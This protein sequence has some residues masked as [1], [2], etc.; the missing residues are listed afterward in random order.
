MSG[1]SPHTHTGSLTHTGLQPASALETQLGAPQT[2]DY[3]L[4]GDLVSFSFRDGDEEFTLASFHTASD[5]GEKQTL[6]RALPMR[7][8]KAVHGRSFA[9]AC[10]FRIIGEAPE[11]NPGDL[12]RY[13]TDIMLQH[14]TTGKYVSWRKQTAM[15][16]N[17]AF[18][19]HLSS[20]PSAQSKLTISPRYAFRAE[21]DRVGS[22]DPVLF[23]ASLSGHRDQF[24]EAYPISHVHS[25][26]GVDEK[27]LGDATDIFE[28]NMCKPRV[29]WHPKMFRRYIANEE[30]VLK[31]GDVIRLV[32]VDTGGALLVNNIAGQ[33]FELHVQPR[34]DPNTHSE[35]TGHDTHISIDYRSWSMWQVELVRS[36]DSVAD[37][38]DPSGKVVRREQRIRLR[39]LSTSRYLTAES[40]VEGGSGVCWRV[41]KHVSKQTV[42]V[43]RSTQS[44]EMD[45]GTGTGTDNIAYSASWCRIQHILTG[46]CIS[47]GSSGSGPGRVQGAAASEKDEKK[48]GLLQLKRAQSKW[49]VHSTSGVSASAFFDDSVGRNIN[50]FG[51]GASNLHD[52]E[53]ASVFEIHAVPREDVESFFLV[54]SRVPAMSDFVHRLF[55][56][57]AYLPQEHTSRMP[58][59][60]EEG[61][62]VAK[63]N[64]H[65][66]GNHSENR[67]DKDYLTDCASPS[68]PH[69]QQARAMGDDSPS[70]MLYFLKPYLFTRK[71]YD[72]PETQ[73]LTDKA[74]DDICEV[75]DYL[76]SHCTV[77]AE[78]QKLSMRRGGPILLHQNLI[79][80][81]RLI[82]YV[83]D[84][85]DLFFYLYVALCEEESA[86][87]ME[88]VRAA[89]GEAVEHKLT[90]SSSGPQSPSYYTAGKF[91]F[92]SNDADDDTLYA[93][94]TRILRYMQKIL[95]KAYTFIRLS[96]WRNPPMQLY[97]A[98]IKTASGDLFYRSLKKHL[99]VPDGIGDL[100]IKALRAI[101]RNNSVLLSEITASE[102][103]SFF[104]VPLS[105]QAG[106]A[107]FLAVFCIARDDFGLL[108]D[109]GINVH[110]DTCQKLI[111]NE[112][113]LQKAMIHSFAI[114]L[115]YPAYYN[116][117]VSGALTSDIPSLT[118]WNVILRRFSHE[119]KSAMLKR[120]DA[121][122]AEKKDRRRTSVIGLTD[123]GHFCCEL[124]SC[125]TDED[126]GLSAHALSMVHN[127]LFNY[128]H[129][130]DTLQ[131]M[132]QHH[133][134]DGK[135]R[136]EEFGEQD[137]DNSANASGLFSRAR[138]SFSN[139]SAH[140]NPRRA[141]NRSVSGPQ[142]VGLGRLTRSRGISM[143]SHERPSYIERSSALGGATESVDVAEVKS[144][145]VPR[146][147]L[148]EHTGHRV[149]IDAKL[150]GMLRDL[151]SF[152]NAKGAWHEKRVRSCL[153]LIRCLCFKN[154][155][156]S[157][158]FR[159]YFSMPIL[160]ALLKEKKEANE[161]KHA[162]S[163]KFR[164]NVMELLR[165][166]WVDSTVSQSKLQFQSSF[167]IRYENNALAGPTRAAT[168]RHFKKP[169]IQELRVF[170]MEALATEHF[171][172]PQV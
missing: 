69:Y 74:A 133:A 145:F 11:F 31:G 161:H 102:I 76:S 28:V 39:N 32:N 101:Y 5:M 38:G 17:K 53:P 8:A 138:N 88:K 153:W 72:Y 87:E 15:S 119:S 96:V 12:V 48:T 148:S 104:N 71:K 91:T 103:E 142:G 123:A 147:R 113:F 106:L 35:K 141:H 18:E 70:M 4:F 152:V 122:L 26:D 30:T 73:R 9:E 75:L 158:T 117:S 115:S 36:M 163:S 45:A 83:S 109:E 1:A 98:H 27:S 6:C 66:F 97:A 105:L 166:F 7:S 78:A 90:S 139:S 108:D 126:L 131:G 112:A 52:H 129:K 136:L 82:L 127:L 57:F 114:S 43:L 62:V 42:F 159:A 137:A 171:L 55:N 23:C 3:L 149:Q 51:L 25:E 120:V 154:R 13:G 140:T 172:A 46:K 95:P 93:R 94:K 50:Y 85:L 81:Q 22:D 21:G 40:A 60:D 118:N 100:A 67:S 80:D 99:Y 84:M 58:R 121:A 107:D 2:K 135:K 65:L 86:L 24:L 77:A 111:M 47:V 14:L 130:I 44:C 68:K 132:L 162:L 63:N 143:A 56:E 156:N 116:A 92:A 59:V 41:T 128:V 33:R 146:L 29:A 49:L 10:V 168:A 79:R 170:V 165:L 19:V 150:N 54:F 160:L 155:K 61:F 157:H 151:S 34:E 37:S 167:F 134:A 144:I 125:N 110:Q 16:N 89:A 169:H 64:R 164:R 20:N 124:P